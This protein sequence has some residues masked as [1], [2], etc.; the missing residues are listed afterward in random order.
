MKLGHEGETDI[1]QRCIPDRSVPA[2]CDRS[3][4]SFRDLSQVKPK[5]VAARNAHIQKAKDAR[6]L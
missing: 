1:L 6:L 2:K 5:W 3:G 4:S